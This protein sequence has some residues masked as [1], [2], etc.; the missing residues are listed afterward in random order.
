MLSCN[1]RRT[2]VVLVLDCLIL[3]LYTLW[4]SIDSKNFLG[5]FSTEIVTLLASDIRLN[6]ISSPVKWIG[7]VCL[8]VKMS[9]LDPHV[10]LKHI[11]YFIFRGL[12]KNIWDNLFD[13][14]SRILP[15]EFHGTH[16]LQPICVEIRIISSEPAHFFCDIKCLF[17][18]MYGTKSY[19]T[20]G[21]RSSIKFIFRPRGS[22]LQLNNI[23]SSYSFLASRK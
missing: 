3:F 16:F 4:T 2:K 20:V 19:G 1:L 23:F 12:Y 10:N 22:G 5:H 6:I 21:P 7:A 11:L 14:I 8:H 18:K 15:K 13:D 9:T 17:L